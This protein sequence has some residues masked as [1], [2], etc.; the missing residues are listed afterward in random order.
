MAAGTFPF[1]VPNKL[2]GA[3]LTAFASRLAVGGLE[4]HLLREIMQTCFGNRMW[5]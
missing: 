1:L 5:K 4:V 3:A 2:A